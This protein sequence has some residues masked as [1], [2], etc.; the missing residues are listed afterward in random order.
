MVDARDPPST[1][2][3][4]RDLRNSELGCS[5]LYCGHSLRMRQ[6]V[7]RA[8]QHCATG[9]RRRRGGSGMRSNLR[10]F[11]LGVCV[12]SLSSAGQPTWGQSSSTG[13]LTG[14]VTD[15]SGGSVAGATI[16][17]TNAATQQVVTKISTSDGQYKFVPLA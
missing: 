1:G 15:P 17:L 10:I 3:Y 11:L 16:A 14:T 2:P 9:D 12:A 5:E 8:A 7:N 4:S 13:A 6:P